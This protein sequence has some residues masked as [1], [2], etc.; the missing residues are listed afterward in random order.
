MAP[1]EERQELTKIEDKVEFE[2]LDFMIVGKSIQTETTS[3]PKKFRGPNLT[4]TS[5]AISVDRV[6]IKI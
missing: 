6:S 4:F 2:R 1:K 3:S 5:P